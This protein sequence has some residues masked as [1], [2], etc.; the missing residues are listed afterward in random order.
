[1]AITKPVKPLVTQDAVG[2]RN[3]IVENADFDSGLGGQKLTIVLQYDGTVTA[4]PIFLNFVVAN[5]A[6][7]ATGVGTFTGTVTV[8]WV[9]LTNN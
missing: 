9:N 8:T 7:N 2:G 4:M 5:D 1:M 6:S 3:L